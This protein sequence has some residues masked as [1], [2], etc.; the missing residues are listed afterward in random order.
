MGSYIPENAYQSIYTTAHRRNICL[1]PFT[2][3]RMAVYSSCMPDLLWI[4]AGKCQQVYIIGYTLCWDVRDYAWP[5]EYVVDS[6]WITFLGWGLALHIV[7]GHDVV[8]IR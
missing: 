5:G 1:W 6:L 4:V 3:Q 7:Y 8:E 2:V